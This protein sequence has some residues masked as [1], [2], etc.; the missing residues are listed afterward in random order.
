MRLWVQEPQ[1]NP[2]SGRQKNRRHDPTPQK[3]KSGGAT[4][5]SFYLHVLF[6]AAGKARNVI[7]AGAN[8]MSPGATGTPTKIGQLVVGA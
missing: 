2:G 4:E 8:E 6:F 1:A 3:R 7:M 5:R